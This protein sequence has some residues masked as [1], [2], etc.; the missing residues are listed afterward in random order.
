MVWVPEYTISNKFLLTIREIGE[1]IGEIKAQHLTHTAVAKLELN[2]RELSSYASTNIEGN[3]LPLT[4]VK[5]LL[6]PTKRAFV[7]P[8]TRCSITIEPCKRYINPFAKIALNSMLKHWSMFKDGTASS[9]LSR[10]KM[11]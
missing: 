9:C 4:D 3:P 11:R 10:P 2:A 1:S 5:R 7:I 8:N 6:K